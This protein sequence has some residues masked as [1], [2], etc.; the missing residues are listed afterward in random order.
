M[1]PVFTVG[2]K[3]FKEGEI[4]EEDLRHQY[5]EP[6]SKEEKDFNIAVREDEKG[7]LW[8][9]TNSNDVYSKVDPKYYEEYESTQINEDFLYPALNEIFE[10]GSGTVETE[11]AIFEIATI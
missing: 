4:S 5:P 1:K 8:S 2:I 7:R 6:G 11:N 3:T 10:K 9:V